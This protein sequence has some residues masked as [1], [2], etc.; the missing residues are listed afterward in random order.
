MRKTI[1]LSLVASA[2]LVGCGHTPR[3]Q[4]STVQTETA[5]T[6]YLRNQSLDDIK[7]TLALSDTAEARRLVR[8]ALIQVNHRYNNE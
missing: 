2:L 7:A 4:Y 6:L 8:A 1:A 5:L 3:P